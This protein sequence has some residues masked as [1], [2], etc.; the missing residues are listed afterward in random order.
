MDLITKTCLSHL[1][2]DHPL[3]PW[4]RSLFVPSRLGSALVMRVRSIPQVIHLPNTFLFPTPPSLS[5][6]DRLSGGAWSPTATVWRFRTRVRTLEAHHTIMVLFSV[7]QKPASP[8]HTILWTPARA[9]RIPVRNMCITNG[10]P[11][12]LRLENHQLLYVNRMLSPLPGA[13]RS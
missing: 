8:S 12:R 5:K 10:S 3:Q 7:S 1:S 2:R 11:S 9:C 6:M 4:G 13:V